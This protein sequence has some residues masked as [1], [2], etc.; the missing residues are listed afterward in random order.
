MS[1]NHR[2]TSTGSDTVDLMIERALSS[3]ESVETTGDLDY[4]LGFIHGISLVVSALPYDAVQT[5]RD[6]DALV[7]TIADRK[8]AEICY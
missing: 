5:S 6:V 1:T 7:K 3:L 8:R 4:A 2:F